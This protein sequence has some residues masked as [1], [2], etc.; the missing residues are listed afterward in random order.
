M[1]VEV[2]EPLEHVSAPAIGVL[3]G[4]ITAQYNR[5]QQL[6]ICRELVEDL[7]PAKKERLGRILIADAKREREDAEHIRSAD[8]I[9]G[10]S[11]SRNAHPRASSEAAPGVES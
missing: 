11:A 8:F 7:S 4:G 1:G 9:A 5:D 6:E 3:V 2:N 10:S